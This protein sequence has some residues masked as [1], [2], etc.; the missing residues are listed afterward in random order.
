MEAPCTSE[1]SATTPIV[2]RFNVKEQTQER[3]TKDQ[4]PAASHFRSKLVVAQEEQ[5]ILVNDRFLSHR[6]VML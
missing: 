6:M 1:T 3:I 2:S 4:T 5:S